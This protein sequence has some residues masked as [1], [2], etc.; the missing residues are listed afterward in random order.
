MEMFLYV[1]IIALYQFVRDSY[2]ECKHVES[3]ARTFLKLSIFQAIVVLIWKTS[4]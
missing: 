1:K 4:L 2:Q 3:Y